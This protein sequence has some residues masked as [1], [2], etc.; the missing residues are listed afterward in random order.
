MQEVLRDIDVERVV[1]EDGEVRTGGPMII[2]YVGYRRNQ[3]L[4]LI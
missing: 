2:I 1:N 4:V 3:S